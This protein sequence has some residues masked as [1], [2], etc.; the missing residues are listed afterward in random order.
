MVSARTHA[1]SAAAWGVPE[2]DTVVISAFADLDGARI[3]RVFRVNVFGTFHCT[4]HAVRHMSND[5]DGSGGAIINISSV[6]ARLGAASEYVDY[7]ASK[8]AIDTMT[9]G[10][11]KEVAEHGIRVNAIRPGSCNTEI[12]ALGGE[13]DRVNRVAQRIPMKRGG[14]PREVA[15]AVLWLA[16]AEASYITGS[17]L[18]VTGGI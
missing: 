3:Q 1:P 16:S 12:H 17:I 5:F 11:A 4:Q 15:E 9:I 14:D 2:N 10:L 7:A 13:P 18:D 8:A 6:A